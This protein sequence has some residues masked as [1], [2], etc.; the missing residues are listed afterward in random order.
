MAAAKTPF[1]M[2]WFY[3]SISGGVIEEPA[4]GDTIQSHL[5]GWHGP[6]AS[7][8]DALN[9]YQA[10]KAANPGWAAPSG[11][12][13]GIGNT[14][15]AGAGAAGKAVLGA[16]WNLT[17]GNTSGLLVRILKVGVGLVLLIAGALK[18][19][20]AGKT[21]Q[22]VVPIVGGPAGRLLKA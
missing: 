6:F 12:L 21:L 17:L 13:G 7:K 2:V 16:G 3:N 4:I 8:Q 10:N 5:P 22:Q 20:G 1:R 9:Y 18:I 11:L 19:S 14:V 15:T